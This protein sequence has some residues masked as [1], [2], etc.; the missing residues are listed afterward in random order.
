MLNLVTT[1][2]T[3]HKDLS[4]FLLLGYS[5]VL[6]RQELKNIVLRQKPFSIILQQL[7]QISNAV[8]QVVF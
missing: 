4:T 8:M 7:S 6:P 1:Y 3:M 5:T 2:A